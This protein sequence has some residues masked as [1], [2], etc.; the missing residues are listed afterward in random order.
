MIAR[1]AAVAAMLAVTTMLPCVLG[2]ECVVTQFGAV[3]DN[4]TLDTEAVASAISHCHSAFPSGAVVRFPAPG[5]CVRAQL[6]VH[7]AA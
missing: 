7:T 4:S 6:H 5:R 1:T 2:G 3:G